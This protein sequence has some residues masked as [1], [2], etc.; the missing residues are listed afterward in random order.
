LILEDNPAL[1]KFNKDIA[2]KRRKNPKTQISGLV[3]SMSYNEQKSKF[4]LFA[5]PSIKNII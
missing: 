3:N 1:S 4:R 2:A 5:N